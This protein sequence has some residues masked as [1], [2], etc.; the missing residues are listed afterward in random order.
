MMCVTKIDD[1]K[2]NTGCN[3]YNQICFSSG[4]E[5]PDIHLLRTTLVSVANNKIIPGYYAYRHD[6]CKISRESRSKM[7][8]GIV[9]YHGVADVVL[10]NLTR[11][12]PPSHAECSCSSLRNVTQS[13]RTVG[14]RPV[15]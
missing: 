10:S 1:G 15:P 6:R 5:S 14:L 12:V 4:F 9:Q 11:P 2:M 7:L 13:P 3:F 8:R